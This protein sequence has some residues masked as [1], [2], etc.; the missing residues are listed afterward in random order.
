MPRREIK[1]RVPKCDVSFT[2]EK[3]LNLTL[4]KK[5]NT[6]STMRNYV[7]SS[8]RQNPTFGDR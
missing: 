4:I 5:M 6:E 1:G 2:F 7:S 8:A 3:I